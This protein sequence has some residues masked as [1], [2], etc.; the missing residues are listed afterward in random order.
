MPVRNHKLV[1]VS[2]AES[3]YLGAA[4]LVYHY[5]SVGLL[6]TYYRISRDRAAAGSDN[7]ALSS[8]EDDVFGHLRCVILHFLSLGEILRT[9]LL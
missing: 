4:F 2:A 9:V 1:S 5:S 6:E 3:L 7:I 8:A